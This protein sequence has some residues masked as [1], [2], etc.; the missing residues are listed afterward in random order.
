MRIFGVG[1]IPWMCKLRDPATV[2]MSSA[3]SINAY[4][5]LR[6][7]DSGFVADVL[8]A[9]LGMP[10]VEMESFLNISLAPS[11]QLLHPG[12]CTRCSRTGTARRLRKRRSSTRDSH[13]RARTSS[14]P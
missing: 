7:A 3:K 11:N 14:V 2:R 9:L 12:I 8:S 5:P 10:M 6:A 4:Q 1:G 13:R